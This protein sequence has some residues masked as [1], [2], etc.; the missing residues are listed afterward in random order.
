MSRTAGNLRLAAIICTVALALTSGALADDAFGPVAVPP[1]SQSFKLGSLKLIALRDAQFVLHNDGKTF[2]SDADVLTI[3][4]LLKASGLPDDRIT[5]SVNALLVR[6]GTRVILID[7]GL[8]AAA[9]GALVASLADAGVAA[10][11]V[12]DVLI[13]HSH[14][15][16]AGGLVDA[17]GR[18]AFPGAVIRMSAAEWAWMKGQADAANLVKAIDG[19]VETFMPGAVLAPGVTAVALPG[20][21]PGHVGYEIVSGDA[22]LLDIG[23]MA[24]SSIISLKKPAWTMQ[25]DGDKTTAAATRQSTFEKLAKSGELVFSPHF[26]FPGVGRVVAGGDAYSWSPLMP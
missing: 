23:D 7:S 4:G 2:G 3:G 8:G 15:D 10:R 24:H 5:L 19:H 9:H 12:T 1:G 20:H 17:D 22:R 13:T 18:L 16:H 21:T 14:F 26:P 6:H 25:Y 11:E